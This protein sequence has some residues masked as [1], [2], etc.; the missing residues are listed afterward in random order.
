MARTPLF[1]AMQRALRL[2]QAADRAGMSA[3]EAQQRWEAAAPWRSRRAF[4]RTSA[5]AM[6]GAVAA[7]A[8]PLLPQDSDAEVVVVGAGIAGLTAAYRLHQANVGVRVYEAQNRIGGR[9]FSLRNHFPDNQVVELGAELIDTDHTHMRALCSELGLTLDDFEQHQPELARSVWYFEGRRYSD[10]EVVRAFTPIAAAIRRDLAT[11]GDGDITYRTPQG[12]EALD[13][14]S[15]SAWFDRHGVSGWI[16]RLLEV[17][18]TAEMGLE[19]EQ[20]SALNLLTLI[21]DD[22]DPFRIF[23]D[24]DERF[25]VRGGNDLVIQELGKRL[26]GRIETG[27]VLEAL[28]RSADGRYR[29]SLRSGAGS[30]EVL[31][32]HVVLTLPVT[33]LRQVRFDLE[34]PEIKR[35][36]IAALAY[37]TNAKLMIGFARRV[38]RDTGSDGSTFS[39]L[40]YQTTWETSRAQPGTAGILTNFVGGRHG[41]E[42][43]QGT[44]ADQAARAV[45]GLD[46]VYPGLAAQRAGM[47]EVRFHWPSNPWVLGS[48][49]CPRPGDWTGFGGAIAEPVGRLHFAGEHCSVDYQGFME[50]GCETGEATAAAL[51]TELG[52]SPR[53]A[54]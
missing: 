19:P 12:A 29:L 9:M 15:L 44:P 17:A 33:M 41:V 28:G 52:L 40:P 46:R 53:K 49:Y 38:W 3:E 37:G 14:E 34:L 13:R 50:G 5:L 16:R 31:A 30:R 43:G 18:Y 20:Q 45:A 54:A 25:H 27:S 1:S 6:A 4:L 36:A 11:I 32:S 2:A 47:T 35:R 42:I 8:K 10:R 22:P 48:Y 24:S 7:C 39:D 23:G 51:L 21:S 26:E